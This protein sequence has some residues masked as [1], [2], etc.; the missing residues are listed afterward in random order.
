M[1]LDNHANDVVVENRT[2][3]INQL[4]KSLNKSN[5]TVT[6]SG[7]ARKPYDYTRDFPES[8]HYQSADVEQSRKWIKPCYYDKEKIIDKLSAG[9][10]C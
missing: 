10:L 4:H 6:R 7:R 1:D 9:M 8:V 2:D 3:E 5:C